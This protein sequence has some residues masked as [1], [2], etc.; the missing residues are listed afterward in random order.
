MAPTAPIVV[1]TTLICIHRIAVY[2]GNL[3]E[4][5]KL[6]NGKWTWRRFTGR[7]TY[8]TRC[9]WFG[10]DPDNKQRWKLTC[11][12]CGE[13]YG[14]GNFVMGNSVPGNGD[15][16]SDRIRS[17]KVMTYNDAIICVD[18][19]REIMDEFDEDGEW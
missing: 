10:L 18:C 14:Q 2:M 11:G 1:Y 5:I 8:G 4:R 9:I 17:I 13:A 12:E 6:E 19:W 7:T 16:H 15:E 3:Y